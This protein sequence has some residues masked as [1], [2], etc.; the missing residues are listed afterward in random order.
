MLDRQYRS[1][2]S[3]PGRRRRREAP[4]P[5]ASFAERVTFLSKKRAVIPH[6]FLR[7]ERERDSLRDSLRDSR[8]QVA[9]LCDRP[10]SKFQ[11]YVLGNLMALFIPVSLSWETSKMS[12]FGFALESCFI[13]P[14]LR[15]ALDIVTHA[16]GTSLILRSK[17][18]RSAGRGR[19]SDRERV[20][21]RETESERG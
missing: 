12:G 3:I 11:R 9:F 6:F 18:P 8:E 16:K 19:H 7:K 13:D 20:R 5:R 10:V 17:S 4:C 15:A 14:V 2:E 1:S 21:E